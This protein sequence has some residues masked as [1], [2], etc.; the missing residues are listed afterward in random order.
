[1]FCSQCG[2]DLAPGAT[3]C[4]RCGRSISALSQGAPPGGGEMA[5][6]SAGAPLSPGAY[7]ST[8]TSGLAIASLVL[9]IL[10]LGWIGSLL[11]VIFGHVALGHIKQSGG[12]MHGRGMAV[13][14]LVLGYIGLAFIAAALLFGFMGA[15]WSAAI[16]T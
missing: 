15:I 4:G 11:A 2:A 14:G 5:T 8:K 12:R 16:P 7:A 10:W 1:M 13:A 3:F 6:S 9:G